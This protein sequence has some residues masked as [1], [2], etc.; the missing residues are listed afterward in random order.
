MALILAG[1]IA[2]REGTRVAILGATRTGKSTFAIDFVKAMQAAQVASTAIVHDVKYPH[3][4]QY[5]GRAVYDGRALADAL[6]SDDPPTTLVC[7][8][9]VEADAAAAAVRACAEAG[10]PAVL[11]LDESR[12][13]IG[14]RQ[15]WAGDNVPWIYAEGG[16]LGGSI[17]SL[18]QIPQSFPT[19]AADQSEAIVAFRLGGRSRN[20]CADQAWIPKEAVETLRTL[21]VGEF[22]VFFQDADW[23]GVIYGPR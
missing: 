5:E 18:I 2:S 19:D 14:K 1:P 13:A 6:C 12:R 4:Q 8:P 10:E 11:F 21:A 9:G 20:Y 17:V 16:G 22:C 7:R 15:S 3:R 23:D